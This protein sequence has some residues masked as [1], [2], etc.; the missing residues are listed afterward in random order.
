MKHFSV[1]HHL[2]AGVRLLHS[3]PLASARCGREEGCGGGLEVMST[4]G[5]EFCKIHTSL[6]YLTGNYME[7]WH[8]GEQANGVTTAR[9]GEA[10][11]ASDIMTS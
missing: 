8:N 6:L 7:M 10:G 9:A 3:A 1:T 2:S 4:R 11:N 5:F